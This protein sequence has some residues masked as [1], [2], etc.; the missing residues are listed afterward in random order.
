MKF[1]DDREFEEVLR[2][3]VLEAVEDKI[4]EN[5]VSGE[6]DEIADEIVENVRKRDRRRQERLVER[7]KESIS[8]RRFLKLLG[9]GTAGTALASSGLAASLTSGTTIGGNTALHTGN[10][11]S[12]A[13]ADQVDSHHFVAQ[14]SVPSSPAT[15]TLWYDTDGEGVSYYNGSDWLA[16]TS[17]AYDTA[18]TIIDN[19][20]DGN[21]NEYNEDTGAFEVQTSTAYDGSYALNDTSR[22]NS[23]YSSPG[24]GLNYYPQR[25]DTIEWQ[26]RKSG[27]ND[28]APPGFFFTG[29]SHDTGAS[30]YYFYEGSGGGSDMLI[31]KW[32]SGSSSNIAS[33]NISGGTPENEWLHGRVESTSSD[34][35]F[36]LWNASGTQLGQVS[37]SD[38]DHSGQTVVFN[39]HPGNSNGVRYWDYVR[40]TR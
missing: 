9:L 8:R 10:D 36:T 38:S 26:V 5:E 3:S 13:N 31:Q 32:S 1:S 11:Q 21:L 7:L 16:V 19:F 25:G 4:D 35:T 22:N 37:A 40:K 30:G 18:F 29:G 20:E 34:L 15:G 2:Q 24:D 23:I 17:G 28:Q 12:S 14:S 39:A 33:V 27:G 6:R